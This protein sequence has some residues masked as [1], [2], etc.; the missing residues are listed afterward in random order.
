[1]REV[2]YGAGGGVNNGVNY[3]SV[4]SVN[5]GE[6][7]YENVRSSRESVCE[8]VKLLSRSAM[9]VADTRNRKVSGVQ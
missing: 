3:G 1:M 8:S 4:N 7:Y 5:D 6:V 2:L 9:C